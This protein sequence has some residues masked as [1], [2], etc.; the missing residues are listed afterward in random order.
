MFI[1][2]ICHNY[3]KFELILKSLN[4]CC[5][6][7]SDVIYFK[8][9]LYMSKFQFLWIDT[10]FNV[11]MLI[12]H[13]N[14]TISSTGPLDSTIHWTG[15]VRSTGPPTSPL[16]HRTSPLDQAFAVVRMSPLLCWICTPSSTLYT[17]TTH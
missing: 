5:Q 8:Y 9:I 10:F 11:S 6:V 15:L 4:S 14:N 13:N 3:T 12:P 2:H 17:L 16:D 7:L 1:R